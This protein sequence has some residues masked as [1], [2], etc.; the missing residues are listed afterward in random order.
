MIANSDI[1]DTMKHALVAIEDKRFYQHGGVDYEAILRALAADL[2]ANK[3][4][5]GGSTIT[6]QLV[7]NLYLGGQEP[8]SPTR[9]T[10][11]P[12]PSST[13][14]PTPRTPSSPTTSTRSSSGPMPTG[15]KRP[16]RPTLA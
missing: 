9:F 5:Q 14:R 8:R 13:S 6:M 4:V 15:W 12:W 3:A 16:P 7:K 10:R 1:P 11:P 2:K